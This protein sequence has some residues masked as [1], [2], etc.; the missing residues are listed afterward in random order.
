M[1]V[2]ISVSLNFD[3]INKITELAH[4]EFISRSALV[5]RACIQYIERKGEENATEIKQELQD[6]VENALEEENKLKEL[7]N[8]RFAKSAMARHLDE[9]DALKKSKN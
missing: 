8:I 7:R 4:S 1:R 6:F 9:L 5:E 3:I 2:G